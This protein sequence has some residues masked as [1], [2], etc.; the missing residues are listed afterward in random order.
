MPVNEEGTQQQ[1]Q[2]QQKQGQSQGSELYV[3]MT[4]SIVLK[5]III[6]CGPLLE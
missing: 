4:E 3:C 6:C 5:T 2:Q 1:L